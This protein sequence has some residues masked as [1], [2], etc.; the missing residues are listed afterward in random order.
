MN[1]EQSLDIRV[2]KLESLVEEL[3]RDKPVE[4][5]IQKKMKELEI[6]YSLDPVERINR[7]LELMVGDGKSD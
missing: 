5:Q 3:L 1:R 4:A 2:N 7:V 6:R